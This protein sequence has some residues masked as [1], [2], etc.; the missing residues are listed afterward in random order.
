MWL[1]TRTDEAIKW[2][3]L[4]SHGGDATGHALPTHST[5]RS[6]FGDDSDALSQAP[7]GVRSGYAN[8]IATTSTPELYGAGGQDPY[9]VPP[10]PH[11]N[12]NQPYHDDPGYSQSE[13]Y[14]PYRGPVPD[15]MSIDGHAVAPQGYGGEAIPMTQMART[16][17]PGPGMAYEMGRA[18]PQPTMVNCLCCFY[19]EYLAH[20]RCTSGST[21]S[22]SPNGLRGFNDGRPHE[23][24]SP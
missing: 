12:P 20:V 7:S 13:F 24:S 23:E 5:G 17:S 9:A 3:E 11:L 15:S 8:S 18:S 2:P 21:V 16:R 22:R 19:I 14:D 4:N 10:L 6:G 1:I